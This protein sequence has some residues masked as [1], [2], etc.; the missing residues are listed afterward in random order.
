MARRDARGDRRR[1]LLTAATIVVG[2]AAMVSIRSFGIDLE[3][4]VA[5]E[6]KGLLGA[7]LEIY[8]RQPFDP[9]AERLIGEIGGEQIREISL[10]SMAY[11][12]AS[13][14]SRLVQL[15]AIDPGWPFYGAVETEPAGVADRIHTEPA[16]LVDAGLLLQMGAE[17]GDRVRVGDLELLIAG[18]LLRLPGEVP[19]ASL[20]GPRVLIDR[21]RLEATGLVAPG[22]RVRYAVQFRLD[23]SADAVAELVGELGPELRRLR[24]EAESVRYREEMV[25]RAIEDLREFLSLAALAALLLGIVGVASAASLHA[26]RHRAAVAILRCLGA[27]RSTPILVYGLQSV[28]AALIGSGLGTVVGLGL[29]RLFPEVLAPFL[30][31]TVVG[32]VRPVALIEGALVGVVTAAVFSIAPLLPLRHVRPLAALR[33]DVT[34]RLPRDPLSWLLPAGLALM[35]ILLLGRQSG[36][37]WRALVLMAAMAV[38]LGGL[39]LGAAG[40]RSVARR[41]LD[42]RWPWVW[43]QGVANLYRPRN[44]TLVMVLALGSAVFLISTLL[45]IGRGILD[46][47]AAVDVA[48]GADMVLFDIQ[49][50]QAD[51]VAAIVGT[52]GGELIERVPVVPMR[53]AS[54]KGR[55]VAE[56]PEGEVSGWSLRREYSSTYRAAPTDAEEVLD[57]EW[58]GAVGGPPEDAVPGAAPGDPTWPVPVSLEESIARRLDVAVGDRLGFDV[59]G[60]VIETRVASTRAVDWQQV[61]P[62]F[63]VVFPTGVLEP[64]PHQIVIVA[65]TTDPAASAAVQRTVVERFSNVSVLDLA[66]VLRTVDG[67]L[68][69]V[70]AALQFLAGFVVLAGLAVLAAATLEG[71]HERQQEG[72]LLRTLGASRSQIARI[73]LAEYLALGSIAAAVGSAFALVAAAVFLRYGLEA[74]VRVDPVPLLPVAAAAL[75]VTVVLGVWNGRQMARRTVLDMIRE[76]A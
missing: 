57:G 31:F 6:T 7:D 24:L 10:G 76:S 41:V 37:W 29:Q 25:G 17:V 13:G 56:V 54:H 40:L 63:F 59:Q 39:A 26:R 46:S 33:R 72:L 32:A 65:R 36:A 53:L 4:A 3:V 47:V 71:R 34:G 15:R 69:Q 8:S 60:V 19:T 52:S 30:P 14:E 55:A 12:P 43:R 58:I 45:L 11:F 61:R 64:A 23:D 67:V 9:E 27:D 38:M 5:A 21:S 50:D 42:R 44:Q 1:L 68:S 62:N 20:V 74:S 51:G 18:T 48:G 75:A 49:P 73:G 35:V 2:V 28:G 16:A 70:R 66:L 22:S